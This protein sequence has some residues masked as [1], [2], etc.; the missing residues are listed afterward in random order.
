MFSKRN[1]KIVKIVWSVLGIIVSVSM[2]L[3]Y[4]PI[5]S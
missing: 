5:F 3:L 1:K 2:I 4:T